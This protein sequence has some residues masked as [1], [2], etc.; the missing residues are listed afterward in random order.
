MAYK[1]RSSRCPASKLSVMERV[2]T[3]S[4]DTPNRPVLSLF[5]GAGGL[6][7]G[8][9]RAGF[10]PLLALDSQSVAVETYNYNRRERGAVAH[11][12][13][14]AT[15]KPAAIIDR[16]EQS[17]GSDTPPVGFVGGPPCQAFSE[18]NVHRIENDPRSLLPLA[19]AELLRAFNERYEHR[20]RFFAFENVA[21]LGYRPHADSLCEI[22][23]RFRDAGFEQ[24]E[25]IMLDALDFGVPQRRRRMF[26]VGFHPADSQVKFIS[27][28]GDSSVRVTVREAIGRLKNPVPFARKLNP[29]DVGLHPNHWHMNPRSDKFRSGTNEPGHHLGRSFRRLHWDEPSLTVAFG[30]REVAVHPDGT[31]RLSILEA[32]L[33]Q[34]FPSSYVLRGTLSDQIRLVSDAVPPPLA[35]ALALAVAASLDLND[36]LRAQAHISTNGQEPQLGLAGLQTI[37]PK[38]TR[39]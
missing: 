38:S 15:E 21:G 10:Q 34:G 30:H 22:L 13:D 33:L 11:V 27:P 29:A 39:P 17:A 18:S 3:A 9:E 24:V 37:A 23:Q 26:I 12:V 5:S 28:I 31:R 25:P 4:H 7:L 8:F 16:W 35:E 1:A 19:Y 20:L 6:D 36:A 2:H 14:L 32:M